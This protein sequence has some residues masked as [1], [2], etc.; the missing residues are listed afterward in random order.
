MLGR[1]YRIQ[2]ESIQCFSS[3]MKL[4]IFNDSLI[5]LVTFMSSSDAL[6]IINLA[7]VHV[8]IA[9]YACILEEL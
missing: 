3:V 9:L 6:K 8:C 7:D 2:Y 1:V 5:L 4:L